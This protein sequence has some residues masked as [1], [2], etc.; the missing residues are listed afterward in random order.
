MAVRFSSLIDKECIIV[1][2]EARTRDEAIEELIDLLQKTGRITG[3]EEVLEC[4][5]NRES[6]A[7]T[8]IGH[9]VAIPHTKC[10]AISELS[11]SLGI[12]RPGIEWDAQDGAPCSIIFFM[13][14]PPGKSGPHVQSLASL[15]RLLKLTDLSER[16]DSVQDAS[17]A[18]SA[19][20]EEETQLM[21]L[22]S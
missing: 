4:A 15:A 21:G 9:G 6:Q 8:G 20:V 12:A 16:L 18:Y 5:L 1:P 2:L 17:E 14:A 11:V 22:E 7:S 10:E 19:I 3:K 13:A